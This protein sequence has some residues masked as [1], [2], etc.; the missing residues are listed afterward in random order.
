VK[1]PATAREGEA[2]NIQESLLRHFV[3][4]LKSQSWF[5]SQ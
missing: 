2:A 3:G 5:C 1:D 4:V